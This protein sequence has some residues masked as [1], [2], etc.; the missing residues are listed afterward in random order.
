MILNKREAHKS[1]IFL[2]AVHRHYL[3]RVSDLIRMS[4]HAHLRPSVNIGMFHLRA[5]LL[6]DNKNREVLLYCP[7]Q[8]EA[9]VKPPRVT[10]GRQGLEYSL[11]MTASL[12]AQF[13][14]IVFGPDLLNC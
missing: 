1:L 4:A 11:T 8:T 9:A 10:A 6:S 2:A 13:R 5:I 14:P 3:V 7:L 12:Q